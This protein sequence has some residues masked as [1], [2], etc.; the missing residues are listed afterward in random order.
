MEKRKKDSL[1]GNSKEGIYPVVYGKN[2]Q[3]RK[4]VNMIS[5][6]SSFSTNN[7][8]LN[9][10]SYELRY[11]TIRSDSIQLKSQKSKNDMIKLQPL[12]S[13]CERV[14]KVKSPQKAKNENELNFEIR[15][16]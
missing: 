6:K 9:K 7:K 16:K 2:I 13:I 4:T 8:L 3:K 12:M 5:R 10:G 15:K 1:F 14:E 11:T